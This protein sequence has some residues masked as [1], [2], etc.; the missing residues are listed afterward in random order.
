MRD[1]LKSCEVFRNRLRERPVF[2]FT[3]DIDWASEYS[4]EE[5]LALFRGA[6]VPVTVFLTHRSEVLRRELESGN[7]RAGIHPNF[8]AGSSQGRNFTEVLN[9]LFAILPDAL[10]FRSHRYF[11]VNDV[12]DEMYRRGIRYSSN[13]CAL[14]DRAEPFLRRSGIIEFP[15]FFEDGAY[16]YHNCGGGK[17]DDFAVFKPLFS[18]PGLKVIN[19]H[20][21]HLILNTP[22]FL[23]TREIK[24]RLSREEWNDIGPNEA[25]RLRWTG[26]GVRG[27][28]ER[29]MEF[30][31]ADGIPMVYLDELYK[32]FETT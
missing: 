31:V 8:L 22:F 6:G 11:E 16:L 2:C 10:G 3:A 20:P 12:T 30:A 15:V 28:V 23:Y 9:T 13:V 32:E 4:I 27:F 5:S 17:V 1:I 26:P 19:I 14:F 18:E 24:D 21:M 29:I 25:E 7:I